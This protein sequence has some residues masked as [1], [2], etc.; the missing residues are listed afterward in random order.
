MLMSPRVASS[1]RNSGARQYSSKGY[2]WV[3]AK[4]PSK[5][6]IKMEN[7]KRFCLEDRRLGF[8]L[9]LLFWGYHP[10]YKIKDIWGRIPAKLLSIHRGYWEYTQAY[11]EFKCYFIGV[12]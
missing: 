4:G 5:E 12:P 2:V 11:F 10:F 1:G 3:Q 8:A 9:F 6:K 7:T